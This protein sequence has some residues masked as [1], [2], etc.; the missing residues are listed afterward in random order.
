[1][2]KPVF[3]V[4]GSVEW[5]SN[6]FCQAAITRRFKFNRASNR[7]PFQ[8]K[9]EMSKKYKQDGMK[10][11]IDTQRCDRR[12]LLKR[13]MV[14]GLATVSGGLGAPGY[15]AEPQGAPALTTKSKPLD[16]V[17]VGYVG[18]GHQGSGHVQNLLRIE[19]VQIKALCDIVEAKVTRA[20]E[21]VQEAGQPK[22]VAYCHGE[23]DFERMCDEE[24]LDLVYTATP[25]EWHTPVC[26]A[27]METGK[28]AAT[29]I[30]A[31]VTLDECWQ[32]V[33]I[34]ERTGLHCVQMENCCYGRSEMMVLNMVRQGFFGELLHA[35]CGYL[36]FFVNEFFDGRH[37]GFWRRAHNVRRNGDLY[38]THGLGPVA[39]YM[40]INRGDQFDYLVSMSSN[41]RG[42][43]LGAVEARGPDSPE[44]QLQFSKGDV[45]SSL[46]RTKNGRT[47]VLQHNV[48]TPRPYN[49]V[50]L[51]QGT[52]GIFRGYPDMIF[53]KG[54]TEGHEYE[55]ASKYQAE[56]EHPLWKN[57]GS[58]ASIGGHEGMDYMEDYRLITALRRGTATDMDVYDAAALSSV[59]ELSE[60][61]VADRSRPQ[62]FP[63]FT[64]GKWKTNPP[65]EIVEG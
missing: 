21:W 6:Y 23:T 20:Q 30:P 62:D 52:N 56:Y 46:I 63:D 17:R 39:Q 51:I 49:R 10:K 26:M 29:E 9:I 8:K 5:S 37:E 3:V 57:L 65:L 36:H 14:A 59:S 60:R 40:D 15:A 41:A 54:K 4:S 35:E 47:I 31:A 32:L 7:N 64:R 45:V 34:A 1:M 28:H 12:D 58:Q 53:I 48:S 24:D 43:H 38:P 44:A 2:N 61:S 13:G 42:F 19:G 18:V 16:M 55:S 50:N 25:W 11:E 22:P 27:A 33:E